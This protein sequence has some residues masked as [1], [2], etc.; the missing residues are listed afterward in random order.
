MMKKLLSK[1]NWQNKV[2][3][4]VFALAV[5]FFVLGALVMFR[6]GCR[7]SFLYYLREEGTIEEVGQSIYSLKWVTRQPSLECMYLNIDSFKPRI[8]HENRS[9]I[10]LFKIGDKV[11]LWLYK[12]NDEYIIEQAKVGNKVLIKHN[13]LLG[14]LVFVITII[15]GLLLLLQLYLK[16][17]LKI[18][19]PITYKKP[20]NR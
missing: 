8:I 9:N 14:V 11:Q 19:F 12:S 6:G 5:V 2:L 16:K 4:G 1:T 10:K 17:V 7:P 20:K 15:S 13:E 18:K 3:D